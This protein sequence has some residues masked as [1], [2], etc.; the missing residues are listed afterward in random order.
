MK[1]TVLVLAAL[2]ALAIPV[3]VAAFYCGIA[4]VIVHFIHKLW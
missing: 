1:K 4:Y 3:V 2:V